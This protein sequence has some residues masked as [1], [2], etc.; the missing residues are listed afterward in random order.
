MSREY[1][2]AV[3]R[4]VIQLTGLIFLLGPPIAL[5]NG[6]RKGESALKSFYESSWQRQRDYRSYQFMVEAA[7]AKQKIASSL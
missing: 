4:C 1:M 2:D 5:A 3:R 7:L 6:E